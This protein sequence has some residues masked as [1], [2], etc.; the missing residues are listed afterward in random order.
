MLEYGGIDLWEGIDTNKTD[1]LREFI[2]CHYWYSLEINFRFDPKIC[3][4]CHDVMQKFVN[5]L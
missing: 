5:F 2:I 3:N 4:D 1:G